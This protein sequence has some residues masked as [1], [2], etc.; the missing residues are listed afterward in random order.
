M[1]QVAIGAFRAVMI[2]DDDLLEPGWTGQIGFVT[3]DAMAAGGFDGQDV[4]VVGV[5]PTHAVAVLAR[6]R[7]VRIRREVVQDVGVTLITGFLARKQGLASIG[8]LAQ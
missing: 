6:K 5:L 4:R 2:L 3:P 7:F 1:G 8:N